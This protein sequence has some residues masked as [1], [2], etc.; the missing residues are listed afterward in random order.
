MDFAEQRVHRFGIDGKIHKHLVHGT[1]RGVEV[2]AHTTDATAPL[3]YDIRINRGHRTRTKPKW[4]WKPPANHFKDF[5]LWYVWAGNGIIEW[6]NEKL[7]I[8][9]G[10]AIL[11]RPKESITVANNPDNPFRVSVIH[12]DFMKN[13]K[14]V[15]PPESALPP[16]LR[17][18][19]KAGVSPSEFRG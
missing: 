3:A 9:Y 7:N 5:D 12:F 8:A 6:K 19:D 13:G 4:F 18:V 1:K 2:R 16:R 14:V 17:Q 15:F 10:S 11:L